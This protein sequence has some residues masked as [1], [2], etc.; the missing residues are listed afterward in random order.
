MG[1]NDVAESLADGLISQRMILIAVGECC[2]E[3]FPR[4]RGAVSAVVWNILGGLKIIN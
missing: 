3:T 2:Q 1:S 4:K